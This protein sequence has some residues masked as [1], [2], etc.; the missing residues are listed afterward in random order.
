MFKFFNRVKNS[1][2]HVREDSWHYRLAQFAYFG[3]NSRVK[4][5]KAC[6]Y[7]WGRVLPGIL[8]LIFLAPFLYIVVGVCAGAIYVLLKFF[9]YTPDFTGKNPSKDACYKYKYSPRK[10]RYVRFAPWEVVGITSVVAGI[11]YLAAFNQNLGLSVGKYALFVI[12][13]GVALFAVFFVFS[14]GWRKYAQGRFSAWWNK[15]CP[16]LVVDRR[17]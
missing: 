6:S 8:G 14:K 3:R 7:W 4:T 10:K 2:I 13:G 16:D 9:G 11:V 15:V 12:F 5:P 17:K 1:L